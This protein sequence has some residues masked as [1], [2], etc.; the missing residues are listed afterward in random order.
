MNDLDR[1]IR[2]ALAADE[3]DLP[4]LIDDPSLA[5]QVIETFR[6]RNRWLVALA[7]VFGTGWFLFAV[8]AA[9]QF[10]RAEGVREMIAWALGLGFGLMALAM[11]KIWYWM[12]LNKNTVT[13]EV[14][15][16][17]LQLAQLIHQLKRAE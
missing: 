10:F 1:K 5:E 17:E 11:I 6:G 13:R 16:V 14:K 3:A 8:V 9:V 7:F 4:G 12:E 2:E 15:R